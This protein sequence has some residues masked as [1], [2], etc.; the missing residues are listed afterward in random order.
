MDYNEIL[1]RAKDYIAQEQ[2]AGFRQ[3]R[4]SS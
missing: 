4:C 3:E 1:R 2:D